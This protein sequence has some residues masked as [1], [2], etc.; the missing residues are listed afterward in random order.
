MPTSTG[1]YAG[2][3]SYSHGGDKP[4][5]ERLQREV[6]RFAKPWNRIRAIRLFRDDTNLTA[7]PGLWTAIETA[8]GDS[9]WFVLL[10]S[11]ES[12]RSHWV[13]KEI[14]WWLDTHES[15]DRLLMVLTAG[16]LV[17]DPAAGSFDPEASTALP[18]GLRTAFTEEPLWV[19]A[20]WSRDVSSHDENDPRMQRTVVDIASTLRGLEKDAL[21][22]EAAREH[23]RTRRLVRAAWASL[24]TLL[25]LALVAAALAW[26]QRGEALD[27]KAVAIRQEQVGRS[28]QLAALAGQVIDTDLGLAGILAAEAFR[29]DRN[30]QTRAALMQT[31]VSSPHLER[32]VPLGSDI[33]R[34]ST[35]SS[36]DVVVAGLDD[37]RVVSWTR[38]TDEVRTLME[39]PGPVT[40][41]AS[42]ADGS[43]VLATADGALQL[44]ADGEVVEIDQAVDDATHFAMAPDGSA[45][46]V[47]RD[48]EEGA[49]LLRVD[50]PS[51][52]V[53]PMA[54][55]DPEPSGRR[56][57]ASDD[58]VVLFEEGY[59]TW[60]V[61]DADTGQELSRGSGAFGIHESVTAASPNGRFLAVTNNDG[62]GT[63]QLWSSADADRDDP[64]RIT[65][66]GD[67][68]LPDG[69]ALG[70][71]GNLVALAGEGGIQV[72]PTASGLEQGLTAATLTGA[73]REAGMVVMD[74]DHLVTASD[75][76]LAVWDLRQSDRLASASTVGVPSGCSACGAASVAV[77]PDGASIAA[78]DGAGASGVVVTGSSQIELPR[79]YDFMYAAP[80]WSDRVDQFVVPVYPT[81]G[82]TAPVTAPEIPGVTL[83]PLAV[84]PPD[85]LPAE[86]GADADGNVVTVLTAGRTVTQDAETGALLG[87]VDLQLGNMSAAALAPKSRAL[88]VVVDG[89]ASVYDLPSGEAHNIPG[90][91]AND[92]VFSGTRLLVQ[93]LDGTIEVWGDGQRQIERRIR[94]KVTVYGDL[95]ADDQ[96]HLLARAREDGTVSLTDLDT[97]TEIGVLGSATQS[98]APK[99]AV[100][101]DASGRRV[102]TLAEQSLDS[103][104]V[105]R[106]VSDAGLLGTT[107]RIATVDISQSDWDSVTGG[108]PLPREACA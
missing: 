47:V 22:G 43:I 97:G 69:L 95:S 94:G 92:V 11:P 106:D 100:V 35:G 76:R 2:F 51:G 49:T 18:E 31:A 48:V 74:D 75:Q 6:E 72:L 66:A 52:A 10:V 26:V 41:V 60:S 104:L 54:A 91:D 17:W 89:H 58:Q 88:A 3:I 55:L 50:G 21:V 56:I 86:V 38:E 93:R 46:W 44:A 15:T 73:S 34:V 29:I 83:W 71:S 96:G 57:F 70:D 63:V 30:P 98:I 61:L 107:C 79:T 78:V 65:A 105:I 12:A 33:T 90:A 108:L 8:L 28:R 59:G 87:E 36:N 37:G 64:E 81:F 67:I 103:V 102:F 84:N 80:I 20:R 27:Q 19:D 16:E 13:G 42:S 9:E 101:F 5:A 68:G 85:D 25:V 7:S 45:G 1:A 77:S 32:F 23:R 40:E 62:G 4:F 99:T 39:L 82:A 14:A 24:G 53:T